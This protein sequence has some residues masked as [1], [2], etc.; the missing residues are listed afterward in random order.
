MPFG[1]K[2]QTDVATLLEETEE[3]SWTG[4]SVYYEP[5]FP[6]PGLYR[7]F[8]PGSA[9]Y[10][11]GGITTSWTYLIGP[12]RK[13]IAVRAPGQDGELYDWLQQSLPGNIVPIP[14]PPSTDLS[15]PLPDTWGWPAFRRTLRRQA[16]TERLPDTLGYTYLAWESS[17]G[18][19]F[20]S[21]AVVEGRVY[22]ATDKSGL[23]VLSLDNGESL[24]TFSLGE[25]WWTSPVVAGDTVYTISA[26]GTVVAL[27]RMRL[28]RL[29]KQDLNGLITSSPIVNEGALFVGS[30]NGAVYA[31]DA[32]T[33]DELWKFQT[34]GEI[35][36]SPALAN[37]LVII[38]SGDRNLYA[39]D[40]TTGEEKWSAPTGGAVDSSP[41]VG[42]PDV[43]VGSFDGCLYSMALADGKINWRCELGGWVHS[44]PALD[45]QTAFVGTV[46]IRRDEIPSFN[47]IGRQ[48]GEIKGQFEMPAPVYSSPTIWDE[49]VL[50][51]CRDGRLYAFDRQMSQ[52]QPLWTYKTR[53]YVHASPV[54]VGDTVLVASFD[55]RLYALR[56]S[57]PIEAWQD[58]DV[59]P[60]WFM[61]ALVKQLHQ[62]TAAL[63][64]QA[65]GGE[66]GAELSLAEA[67][68]LFQQ[69]RQQVA[70]PG[71]APKV[72]PR[73]VP[74]GHPGAPFVEYVL[75]GGLLGGYPD[76]TFKPSQ[77]TTRYQFASALSAVLEWVTRPDYG[78]RVLKERNI[79]GVQVQVRAEPVAG[80]PPVRLT[81]VPEQHWANAALFNQ[82]GKGLL[83]VDE[84]GRFRGEKLVTLK[85]AATQWDLIAKSVKVVRT[86]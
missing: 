83:I 51:G 85:G 32:D 70:E 78:W 43:I 52:T 12:D 82:A 59:V 4:L 76:G 39:L 40:A 81:D 7:T 23:Q 15:V 73:D 3:K 65:A 71:A 20:A 72:L 38:G 19:T 5:T 33:G 31:L 13:I 63:I 42:G 10:G 60:R 67:E 21:P 35:S 50:V 54:V 25:S 49:V 9:A 37:G 56:Q 68:G 36:S 8:R 24:G 34:G 86:K 61:A 66:V 77:P 30:R 57:K 55:G 27:D 74:A 45:D 80:R 18:R 2:G 48:T 28:K 22:V 69:I 46:N 11:D 1:E 6:R 58:Q 79:A 44:S 41:T 17:V 29:W 75:T 62:E 53:S 16:I 47:W 64:A 84:E 26:E 14:R